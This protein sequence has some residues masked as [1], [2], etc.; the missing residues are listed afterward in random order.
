MSIFSKVFGNSKDLRLM[1]LIMQLSQ[2]VQASLLNL[3]NLLIHYGN[4]DELKTSCF[5]IH[6]LENEGDELVKQI[7]EQL[8]EISITSWINHEMVLRLIH[9]LDD[10]LDNNQS[11][12]RLTEN[13]HLCKIPN[14]MLLLGN[15]LAEGS[16]E[17]YSMM[18]L[19]CRPH[20]QKNHKQIILHIRKIHELEHRGD[21]LKSQGL[22][23]LLHFEDEEMPL[24]K[25]E[26][27]EFR[28]SEKMLEILEIIT[29]DMHHL[30]TVIHQCITE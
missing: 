10:L 20:Y 18:S 26:L 15:V 1:E 27:A 29:D 8:S 13:Y 19:F 2:K 11:A 22:H 30:S 6:T 24:T 21:V 5:N 7:A 9:I 3:N 25:R 12:V 14:E 4:E 28:S 17:I 16:S 23:S